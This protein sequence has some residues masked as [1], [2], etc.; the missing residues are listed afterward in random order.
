MRQ[1]LEQAKSAKVAEE[2]SREALVAAIEAENKKDEEASGLEAAAQVAAER[3]TAD[4]AEAQAAKEAALAKIMDARAKAGE[5][6]PENVCCPLL[7][8][9][10][11]NWFFPS[12]FTHSRLFYLLRSPLTFLYYHLFYTFVLYCILSASICDQTCPPFDKPPVEELQ[13]RHPRSWSRE[14]DQAGG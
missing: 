12:F 2:R 13:G 8:C 9:S 11:P 7:K 5:D 4:E 6:T 3:Q 14:K 10:S 1:E